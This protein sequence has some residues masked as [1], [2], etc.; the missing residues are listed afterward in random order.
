M[1]IL[2]QMMVSVDTLTQEVAQLKN[3]KKSLPKVGGARTP[4]TQLSEEAGREAREEEVGSAGNTSVPRVPESGPTS[5]NTTTGPTK[6]LGP[7]AEFSGNREELG[8]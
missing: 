3:E 2:Q 5:Q 6:N 8:P 4:S 7:L 1:Q